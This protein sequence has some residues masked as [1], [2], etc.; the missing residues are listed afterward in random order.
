MRLIDGEELKT[1]FPPGE[2]VRTEC[3]RATIDHMPTIEPRPRG[4]WVNPTDG[5]WSLFLDCSKCGI[6]LQWLDHEEY[7]KF[8][9]VCG[10]DMRGE[11]HDD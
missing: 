7:P 2:T 3:V 9:P 4:K 11:E 5:G 10:A 8:C 6:T 1:A